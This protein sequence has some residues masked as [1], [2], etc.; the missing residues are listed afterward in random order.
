MDDF[1]EEEIQ[2]YKDRVSKEKRFSTLEEFLEFSR[3]N[4]VFFPQDM[5]MRL[6]QLIQ[7]EQQFIDYLQRVCLTKFG[8][9]WSMW[10]VE[11][12]LEKGYVK[13]TQQLRDRRQNV[14]EDTGDDQDAWIIDGEYV[15]YGPDQEIEAWVADY[16]QYFDKPFEVYPE[17]IKV[18]KPGDLKVP[19]EYKDK[20]PFLARFV[21]HD[22]FDRCGSIQGSDLEIIP[23][24][25]L[26]NDVISIF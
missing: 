22:T 11:E 4:F 9:S 19:Q 7:T 1:S 14:L 20:M 17:R 23:I 16:N 3:E 15:E 6:Q 21:S 8:N 12:G 18:F 13:P 26:H 10:L 24:K 25:S 2:A 5:G